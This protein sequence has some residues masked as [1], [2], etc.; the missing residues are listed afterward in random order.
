MIS[1]YSDSIP[2]QANSLLLLALFLFIAQAEPLVVGNSV[3]LFPLSFISYS[4]FS[5]LVLSF[6]SSHYHEIL[7]FSCPLYVRYMCL[8][9]TTYIPNNWFHEIWYVMI[10][11][12]FKFLPSTSV[13]YCLNFWGRRKSRTIQWVIPNKCGHRYLKIRISYNHFNKEH[14]NIAPATF[15]YMLPFCGSDKQL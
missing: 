5:I 3:G 1:C 2:T 12:T 9:L 4:L 11:K 8:Q 10:M 7:H 15:I 6:T 13:C 14:D